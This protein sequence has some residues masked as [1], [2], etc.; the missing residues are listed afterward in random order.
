[1]LYDGVIVQSRPSPLLP[2]AMKRG[3]SEYERIEKKYFR[4]LTL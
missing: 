2:T 3:Q 1:M 4:T